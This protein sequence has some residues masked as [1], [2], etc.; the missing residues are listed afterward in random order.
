MFEPIEE[1]IKKSREER[2][3]HLDRMQPCIEIGGDSRIFRGLLAH[4]LKT[5]ISEN[6]RGEVR[7]ALVCHDCNNPKCSN[8]YHLYW[9]T[10]AD[11]T[12]DQ[13]ERGTYLSIPERTKRKYGESLY[14]ELLRSN[15]S[16]GGKANKGVRK[17]SL[18][19]SQLE[20][21][22]LVLEE[23]DTCKYGWIAEVSEKMEC[24]HTQVRRTV[25]KFFPNLRFFERK[26]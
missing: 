26:S 25:K 14:K 12:K 20:K 15:A 16:K 24:S 10:H 3:S 4:F 23:V 6:K 9:G 1:Y 7:I 2:K 18:D 13:I 17:K 19:D 21:W 22:K 8:P 5:T 11:N